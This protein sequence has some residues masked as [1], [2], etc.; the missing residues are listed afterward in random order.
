VHELAVCQ[1]LIDQLEDISRR[2]QAEKITR[3]RLRIGPLSGVEPQLLEDAYPIAAAGT[4]AD[5]ATLEI[6]HQPVRVHCAVCGHETDASANRLICADCG[7]FRTRLTSGDEMLL[8]S[9]ELERRAN[10]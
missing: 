8:V 6:E 3:V 4:V 2:E 10:A 1:G 9:V 5:G 7:D